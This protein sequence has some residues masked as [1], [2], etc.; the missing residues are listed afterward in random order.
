MQIPLIFFSCLVYRLDFQTWTGLCRHGPPSWGWPLLCH[1]EGWWAGTHVKAPA[2][3]CKDFILNR[4]LICYAFS[5]SVD[6]M[7][8]FVLFGQLTWC[9]T[10][11]FG[12]WLSCGARKSPTRSWCLIIFI[13]CWVWFANILLSIFVSG[14]MRDF[15]LE[16]VFC[17][18]FL[19]CHCLVLAS[20]NK[21][22]HVSSFYFL[23]EIT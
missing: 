4:C 10:L 16:L 14:F 11:I 1:C 8:C 20:K 9:V 6:M 18:L 13:Y 3:V 15:N 2:L 19:Y 7:M 17:F 21:M 12:C 23:E 22:K 5:S